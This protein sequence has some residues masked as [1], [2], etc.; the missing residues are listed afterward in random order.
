MLLAGVNYDPAAAVSKATSSNLAMTALDTTNLRLG[1][2]VPANG[3]VLAKL[4]GAITGS[5][6]VPQ[7]LLGI[8][9]GSTVKLRMSPIGGQKAGAVAA[10]IITQEVVAVVPGLTPGASLNWDAAY[11]V[12]DAVGSTNL[13]Y[14]G[15]N[16]TTGN[17][18]WG[19]FAYEIYDAPNLL[20]AKLYD[21]S[22]AGTK[23]TT[24]LLAMTAF[25]TTNLRITF[26]VPAS[27]KVLVRMRTLLTKANSAQAHILLGVMDGSTVMGRQAP[28]GNLI[29]T[30]AV[31]NREPHEACFLVGG[32]TPGASLTWDAAYGIEVVGSGG[33]PIIGYGGP[34]NTTSDDAY[35]AFGYEI[36]AV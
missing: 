7:I 14:G 31:A 34:N 5:S 30:T 1:F 9:E 8:L 2:T 10:G 17:D 16:N 3:A 11:G 23:V 15:P 6:S 18:A 28:I 12:E 36:W 33:T 35:G 13:K 27:G 20:G 4:R 24:S 21:P 26:T 29:D 25:D 22:S 32:L 19:G